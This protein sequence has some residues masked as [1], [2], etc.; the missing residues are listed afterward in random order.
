MCL[1]APQRDLFSSVLT[2]SLIGIKVSIMKYLDISE[3]EGSNDLLIKFTKIRWVI[4][5]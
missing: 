4:F 5:F 3:N 2:K 1:K